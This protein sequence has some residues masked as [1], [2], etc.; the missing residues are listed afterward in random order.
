MADRAYFLSCDIPLPVK[1]KISEYVDER[2]QQKHEQRLDLL[3]GEL[4]TDQY[5]EARRLSG[6]LHASSG[7]DRHREYYVTCQIFCDNGCPI[8][9][10]TQ[11][12]HASFAK[13]VTWHEWITLPIA[14]RDLPADAVAA[15]TIWD[16]V[17]AR[18]VTAV[19]GTTVS[20]FGKRHELRKGGK[21]LQ[22]WPQREGDGRWRSATP[23]KIQSPN[24]NDRLD[25]LVKSYDAGTIKHLDWLDKLA[26]QKIDQVKGLTSASHDRVFLLVEFPKFELPVLFFER[27]S[28]MDG[29][30]RARMLA[31][32]RA[33]AA[34]PIEQRERDRDREGASEPPLLVATDLASDTVENPVQLKYKVMSRSDRATKL[35]ERDLKPSREEQQQLSTIVSTIIVGASQM[36]SAD[37]NLIWKYRYY[38]SR[39]TFDG[40]SALPKFC[41]VVDWDQPGE[42]Q[43]AVELMSE[44]LRPRAAEALELLTDAF[45][46]RVPREYATRCLD[47]ADDE[48]LEIY[49]PQLVQALR[50]EEEFRLGQSCHLE[51]FL[52]KRA[53]SLFIGNFLAWNLRLE[54]GAAQYAE[55]FQAAYD[56]FEKTMAEGTSEQQRQTWY[57]LKK[58]F[59]MFDRFEDAFKEVRAGGGRAD[60]IK[61]HIR[62]EFKEGNFR[63][64]QAFEPVVLPIDPR[65]SI[66][67]IVAEDINVFKSKTL[68]LGIKFRTTTPPDSSRLPISENPETGEKT[69]EVMWKT[70]DDL[71][72]DGLVLQMFSLMDR[73]LK[74]ENCDMKLSPY[75]CMATS[76][77]DVGNGMMEMVIGAKDLADIFKDW[78]G[79]ALRHTGGLDTINAYLRHY[80]P[81]KGGESGDPDPSGPTF[82]VDKEVY[83]TMI[84]SNA[85]YCVMTYLRPLLN[86]TCLSVSL[87]LCVCVCVSVCLCLCVSAT[88]RLC[89]C[90]CVSVSVSVSVSLCLC[91]CVCVS[92]SLCLCVC[93]SVSVLHA[94]SP[95]QLPA[96]DR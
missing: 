49:L 41:R 31:A 95:E 52:V 68:P 26:F 32:H 18:K 20:L 91:L 48:E 93:V 62:K 79:E 10:P 54:R 42:E 34:P 30:V 55:Q 56:R 53:V 57:E 84:K 15:I 13:K 96:R 90:V 72:Q 25:N 69:V 23:C 6:L 67:G 33:R 21:K 29:A 40:H 77:N 86:L 5:G 64:M 50:Y 11:T 9:L 43:E 76:Y 14:Y 70:G 82:G 61:P 45:T 60:K 16:V 66:T 78:K 4:A 24:D 51:R 74:S 27:F 7:T 12:K 38:L 94:S 36:S 85:G 1:I 92:V 63:D 44:W 75:L 37:Q 46:H 35:A 73:L 3:E 83:E 22:L 39:T 59:N 28:T 2:P 71:R 80:N 19:G 47:Q 89:V 88:L 17:G 8:S 81:A 87:C 65:I 58:S